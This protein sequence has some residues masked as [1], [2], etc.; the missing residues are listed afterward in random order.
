MSDSK[1]TAAF[2]IAVKGGGRGRQAR[3]SQRSRLDEGRFHS[4]Y[5]EKIQDRRQEEVC[6]DQDF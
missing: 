5:E 3:D 1:K 6:L 2:W 4:L